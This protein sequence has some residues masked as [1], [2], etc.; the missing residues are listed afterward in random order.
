MI[1]LIKENNVTEIVGSFDK[2]G[3]ERFIEYLTNMY[4]SLFL[5]MERW[6]TK[7]EKLF[8]IATVMV[9]EK[10]LKY[11]S[12]EAKS[13]Y[14]SVFN[15]KRQSDVRG[16]LNTLEEK[17][18]LVSNKSTKKIKLATY[19]EENLSVGSISYNFKVNR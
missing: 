10:G 18:Y 3:D 2:L 9:S 6:L 17:G 13:I 16:Y 14:E 11:T 7:Q 5:P 15:L 1:D 12:G 4:Q 19:F 8:F